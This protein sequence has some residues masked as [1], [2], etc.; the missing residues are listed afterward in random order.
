LWHVQ[1]FL[2]YIKYIFLEFTPS[3]ILLHPPPFFPK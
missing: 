2:Q 3:P 1:K